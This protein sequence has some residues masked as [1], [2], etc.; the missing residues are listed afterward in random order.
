MEFAQTSVQLFIW[1]YFGLILPLLLL[2]MLRLCVVLSLAWLAQETLQAPI[3]GGEEDGRLGAA[4]RPAVALPNDQGTHILDVKEEGAQQ[5]FDLFYPQLP[6]L[7][8]KVFFKFLWLKGG[9]T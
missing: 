2:Q 5:S 4:Q 6:S 9:G 7:N 8:V 1:L 3:A